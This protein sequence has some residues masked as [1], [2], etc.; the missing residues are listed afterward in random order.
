MKWTAERGIVFPVAATQELRFVCARFARC[1]SDNLHDALQA[2]LVIVGCIDEVK[3]SILSTSP[4]VARLPSSPSACRYHTP[5]EARCA[6]VVQYSPQSLSLGSRVAKTPRP[7][8]SDSREALR[9]RWEFL[10]YGSL[11]LLFFHLLLRNANGRDDIFASR[12]LSEYRSAGT[13]QMSDRVTKCGLQSLF[14][15]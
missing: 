2:D 11:F 5:G 3:G 8:V 4:A 1:H 7:L 10:E 9:Q 14:R 6:L 15:P 12:C 13:D